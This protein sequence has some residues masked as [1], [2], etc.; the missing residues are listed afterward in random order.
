MFP[1][2]LPILLPVLRCFLFPPP[3]PSFAILFSARFAVSLVP[4]SVSVLS[5]WPCR[6]LALPFGLAHLS[7]CVCPALVGFPSRSVPP[8]SGFWAPPRFLVLTGRSVCPVASGL[9]ALS[10]SPPLSRPRRDLSFLRA[11]FLVCLSLFFGLSVVLTFR[12]C[13]FFRPIAFGH[14]FFSSTLGPLCCSHRPRLRLFSVGRFACLPF[15][16]PVTCRA[17]FPLRFPLFASLASPSPRPL[18]PPICRVGLF[19]CRPLSVLAPS[20][21]SS[22]SRHGSPPLCCRWRRHSAF[23]TPLTYCRPLRALARTPLGVCSF[24]SA[25]RSVLFPGP[26]LIALPP[27]L[28]TSGPEC[29]ALPG[30]PACPF[31]FPFFHKRFPSLSV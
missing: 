26:R 10:S 19:P 30:S 17:P 22:S 14:S 15:A 5:V 29:L 25:L 24:A 13:C 9:W 7:V 20:V 12:R 11:T 1:L 18:T 3:T 4:A 31:S 23:R 28:F 16:A 6:S 2:A 8:A 27:L 21:R